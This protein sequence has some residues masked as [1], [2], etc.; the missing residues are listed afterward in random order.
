MSTAR[1]LAANQGQ[2]WHSLAEP[3]GSFHMDDRFELR[4]KLDGQS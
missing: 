4:R 1:E 2:I 3:F